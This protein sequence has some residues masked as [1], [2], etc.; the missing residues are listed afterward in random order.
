MNWFASRG[1]GVE[2]V[3][4]AKAT[5]GLRG[6]FVARER[7]RTVDVRRVVKSGDEN[8][9]SRC[10]CGRWFKISSQAVL[11]GGQRPS[12]T[13]SQP[14]TFDLVRVGE[15]LKAVRPGCRLDI[16]RDD[17]LEPVRTDRGQLH[18]CS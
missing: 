10:G 9:R 4:E 6:G 7:E 3:G 5:G 1:V 18:P 15:S 11:K 2:C 8:R 14:C 12:S 16:A 13:R 17:L